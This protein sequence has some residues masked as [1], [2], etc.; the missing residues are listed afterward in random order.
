MNRVI[1]FEVH[2]AAPERAA[3]FYRRVFGWQVKEWVVP[4]VAIPQENRYWLG[5]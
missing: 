1:H 5:R 3:E 2:A 4:G